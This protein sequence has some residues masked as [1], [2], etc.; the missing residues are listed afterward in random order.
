[1]KRYEQDIEKNIKHPWTVSDKFTID[2]YCINVK[3]W[4]L[5]SNL[6]DIFSFLSA[7]SDGHQKLRELYVFFSKQMAAG[8]HR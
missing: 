2:T 8:V 3:V 4:L 6:L 1:M 7:E 5:H